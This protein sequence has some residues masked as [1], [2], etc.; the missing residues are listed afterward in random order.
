MALLQI[1]DIGVE[2]AMST[3]AESSQRHGTAR[4]T[5]AADQDR[6]GIISLEG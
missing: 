5:R 4:T 3:A 6:T 1:F 2:R